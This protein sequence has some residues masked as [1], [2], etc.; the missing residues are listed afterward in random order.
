MD[1]SADIFL[2]KEY[3]NKASDVAVVSNNL[4]T[5]GLRDHANCSSWENLMINNT[6]GMYLKVNGA[7]L[8]RYASPKFEISD[9]FYGDCFS[10]ESRRN[11]TLFFV[12][13]TPFFWL[14]EFLTLRDEYEPT[15]LKEKLKVI[16]KYTLKV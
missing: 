13:L 3:H 9:D 16:V 5:Q 11:Y 2:A 6:D 8:D 10:Y 15:G 4:I 14:F 7:Q 12:I 1:I